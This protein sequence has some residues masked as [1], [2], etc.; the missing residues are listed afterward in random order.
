MYGSPNQDVPGKID[1][2]VLFDGDGDHITLPRVY[3]SE[4]QFTME[5]WIYAQSGA[6]YFISQRSSAGVFLQLTGTYLQYYINGV[7]DGK[8][9]SLNTWYHVV[10]TY[11]GSTAKLYTNGVARS[12]PMAPPTWPSE[13]M[14]LGDRSTGGRQFL[15]ILDEVRFSNIARSSGWITT[16]YNNQLNPAGF[17]STGPEEVGQ[18]GHTPII[19]NE[20]PANEAINVPVAL[21]QLNFTLADS[22]N[23]LI[24][25]T[26]TTVPDIIGGI[27]QNDD[28][29]SGTTINV[30]INATPLDY[31]TSYTWYVHSTDGLGWSNES[32]NFITTASENTW[33]Y[34]KEITIDHTKISATL[35]NFPILL[36]I[37]DPDLASKAQENGND[38]YF[39][40]S[41]DAK[42][43]HE[44]ERYI[45]ATGELTAWINIPSLSANSDTILYMYYG[46]LDADN[47]ENIEATWDSNYLAV[48]HLAETSGP[49]IDSTFHNNDGTVYGSPN[50]DVL[51]QIDGAVLFDG[52]GDHITL[53][54]VYTSENQFTMEAWIYAQAGARY[55]ISQRS[56]AGVFLQL[57][58]T[59]LQYYINGVSDGKTVSLNTWYH[60]VLTYDGSTAKLYTNGVARSKPMAPPTWPSEGM[61]LGDRSTGGRQFLG[62]LDEVRFS[63]IARSSGWVTTCYNNQLNPASFI[64]I[65]SEES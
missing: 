64:S 29:A 37:T 65:G 23:D 28:I 58:G 61:Y 3:T 24:S 46:N 4:N 11:D 12:K 49:A 22:D 47:Q 32:F 59:Y 57:T 18:T 7:S 31:G 41:T 55:F 20:Q 54:R 8:T 45:A 16:C 9:V 33:P 52:D 53:P 36:K 42:L 17:I 35:S 30:P 27:Y 15:G 56:S 1:R 62:I 39:T 43:N 26:V 48:H 60:V 50:Q 6:R 21:P 44:I 51:G 63:N 13:G 40:D 38:I 19:S 34:R 14:Y 5:A 25:C 2:A 10:L